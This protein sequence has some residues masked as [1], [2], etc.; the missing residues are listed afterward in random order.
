MIYKLRT[1]WWNFIFRHLHL[2]V[3]ANNGKRIIWIDGM[4]LKKINS[5]SGANPCNTL[6]LY[7]NSDLKL[8]INFD[9]RK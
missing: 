8:I 4:R 6:E 2:D 3:Y 1:I 7:I 9:M 5:L